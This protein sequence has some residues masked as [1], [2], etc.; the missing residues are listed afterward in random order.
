MTYDA[1]MQRLRLYD[2]LVPFYHLIDPRADHADEAA[3]LLAAFRSVCPDGKTLLELGAGAG[4]NASFLRDALTCTLTDPSAAMLALSRAANPECEH[5]AGDMRTLRLDRTFDLV[6]LHDA[7]VY[8]RTE[9]DL[10]AAA[11]TAWVHTRPG[12]VAI[13]APDCVRESFAES[14]DVHEGADATRALRCLEWTWDP[15]PADTTYQVEY[16][17]LL[18]DENGVRAVH[19]RHVE[20][21]FS[22]ATW[23]RILTEV[24]FVVDEQPRLLSDEERAGPYA[25]TI[26]VARRPD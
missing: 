3:H 9:A 14:S 8:M 23:R 18:R 10:A 17:F 12:G 1:A 5:V 16:A 2:D 26:F 13:F 20:G 6:L 15:D 11:T 22:R 21:L 24:G 7:V 19:D 25:D 4:N